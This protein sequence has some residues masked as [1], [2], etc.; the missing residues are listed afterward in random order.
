MSSMYSLTHL[1]G[2]RKNEGRVTVVQGFEF[3][4]KTLMVLAASTGVGFIPAII[5]AL[6]ISPFFLLLVPG[7]IAALG[8]WLFVTR[9]REGMKLSRY[10]SIMD[11]RSANL[12]TF[13]ICFEPIESLPARGIVRRQTVE[14]MSAEREDEDN[15]IVRSAVAKPKKTRKSRQQTSTILG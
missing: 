14:V 5:L 8:Y 1:T 3:Q 9:S 10:K 15:D 7:V 13:H 2:R 12:N 11:K 6:T 4:R